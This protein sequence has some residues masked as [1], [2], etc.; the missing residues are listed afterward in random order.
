MRVST[1]KRL[2]TSKSIRQMSAM[3]MGSLM[4]ALKKSAR[5]G[6]S[7]SFL[8]RMVGLCGSYKFLVLGI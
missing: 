8:C 7:Q 3:M 2:R 6:G 4:D 5:G 1:Q